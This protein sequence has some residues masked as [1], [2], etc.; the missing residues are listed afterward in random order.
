MDLETENFNIK[1]IAFVAAGILVISGFVLVQTDTDT[2]ENG[3]F[4]RNDVMFMNM[5]I[6]HHNQAIEMAELSENRT[7]NENILELSN[8]I[9]E[10]QTR[11]NEQ[12]IEWMQEL[13]YNPGNHHPMAGMA[14][15]EE[16]QQLRNSNGS[17]Y[18]QLFA[19]LMIEHHEGGITMAQN[20]YNSGENTELREMQGQ[21]IDAQE[22]EIERMRRW[23]EE[24]IL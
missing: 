12:M 1:K 16:M 6:V 20:F 14:S 3:D 23:Q 21:M 4:N 2:T 24:E 8:N 22:N 15:Q 10:A 11:E 18:N 9:S 19:E 13:G 7:D 5:M 17:E